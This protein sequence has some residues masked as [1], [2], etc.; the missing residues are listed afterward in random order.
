MSA[1][2]ELQAVEG[3][4]QCV[5][6]VWTKWSSMHVSLYNFLHEY[7]D[8]LICFVLLAKEL[9]TN[10]T[11]CA[12]VGNAEDRELYEEQLLKT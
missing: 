12:P 4:S 10:W 3:L 1:H 5:T 8:K 2:S 11:V 6:I 9:Y 7:T